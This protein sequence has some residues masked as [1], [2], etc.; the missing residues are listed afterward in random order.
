MKKRYSLSLEV[1]PLEELRTLAK[2]MRLPSSIVSQIC[3]DA[4]TGT[5]GLLK[6][7]QAKGTLSITDMFT[8]L[9]EQIEEQQNEQNRRLAEEQKG[10]KGGKRQKR[11]AD[12]IG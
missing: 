1:E 9:G 6:S 7:A 3:D 8:F 12:L 10:G 5:L 4:I 2:S 11:I